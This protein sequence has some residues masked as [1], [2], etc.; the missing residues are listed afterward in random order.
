MELFV[1]FPLILDIPP[2]SLSYLEIEEYA[3]NQ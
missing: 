1:L 2:N 3:L